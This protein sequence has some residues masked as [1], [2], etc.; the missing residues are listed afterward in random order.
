MNQS[1]NHLL[2]CSFSI[3]TNILMPGL[4]L[5]V[6]VWR[7]RSMTLYR[8]S[9]KTQNLLANGTTFIFLFTRDQLYIL[10]M[11]QMWLNTTSGLKTG[12]RWLPIQNSKTGN[13]FLIR[14]KKVISGFRIMAATY[15][16]EIL[17]LKFFNNTISEI[18]RP[19]QM[20]R[21][22]YLSFALLPHSRQLK[23]WG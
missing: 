1:I 21:S 19:G 4:V 7:G 15:G 6:T 3:M 8:Q 11:V 14:Q 13:G 12:K 20:I 5:T 18:K 2:R 17:N 16:S 22:F 9:L 10:R 23:L